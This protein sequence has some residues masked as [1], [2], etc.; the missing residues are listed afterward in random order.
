[1]RGARELAKNFLE[2]VVDMVQHRVIPIAKN[3]PAKTFEQAC[4]SA[5]SARAPHMLPA[6]QFD[7]EAPFDARKIHEEC[8]DRMLAAEFASAK[9][10]VPQ[11]A[12]QQSLGVCLTP[13]QLLCA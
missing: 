13:A 9:M 12:P 3:C 11:I 4:P 7:D 6:V 8:P 5:V 1:V 10:P 2:H